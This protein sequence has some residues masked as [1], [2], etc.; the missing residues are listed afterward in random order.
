MPNAERR[1][2]T[3]PY[4][5][6]GALLLFLL[7]LAAYAGDEEAS[8]PVVFLGIPAALV[9]ALVG[10]LVGGVINARRN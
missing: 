2:R 8:D 5:L 1:H 9:G 3:W 4:A 6:A 7:V 10:T